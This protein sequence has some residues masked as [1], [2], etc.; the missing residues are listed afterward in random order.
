LAVLV[1]AGDSRRKPHDVI[2]DG[3]GESGSVEAAGFLIVWVCEFVRGGT[4]NKGKGGREA[5]CLSL[6][7]KGS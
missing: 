4:P 5:R 6:A 7:E 1:D 2:T 3:C